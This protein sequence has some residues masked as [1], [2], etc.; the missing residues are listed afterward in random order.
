M[1][2]NIWTFIPTLGQITEGESLFTYPNGT[3]FSDYY[4]P[5]FV[6]PYLQEVVNNAPPDIVN[7]CSG[8]Q[9]CIFDAVETGDNNIGMGTSNVMDSNNMDVS[10]ASENKK[11]YNLYITSIIHSAF[12]QTTILQPL[13]DQTLSE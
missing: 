8:N 7:M 12:L 3:S 5:D 11:W 1:Y 10:Q 4:F 2:L 6:P 9:Q 13:W